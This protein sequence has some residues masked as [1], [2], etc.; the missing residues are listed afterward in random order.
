MSSLLSNAKVRS[1][2]KNA[3][4]KK[5]IV[6]SSNNIYYNQIHHFMHQTMLNQWLYYTIQYL[7]HN[8][9]S[10]GVVTTHPLVAGVT[11]NSLVA[12]R[13]IDYSPDLLDDIVSVCN[14]L[15]A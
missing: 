13:L 7:E 10:K 1:L 3:G 9:K 15:S 4:S 14:I 2:R 12:L 8:T 5:F 11:I 6:S